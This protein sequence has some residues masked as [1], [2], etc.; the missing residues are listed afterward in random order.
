MLAQ[1]VKGHLAHCDVHLSAGVFSFL[2]EAMLTLSPLID[3]FVVIQTGTGA[4][5]G[6]AGGDDGLFVCVC[7]RVCV[8]VCFRRFLAGLCYVSM[9]LVENKVV[10]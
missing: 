5:C 9:F 6:Y 3:I 4:L 7:V 10:I 2:S 8:W 1:F